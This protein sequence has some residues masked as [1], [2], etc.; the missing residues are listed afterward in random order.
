MTRSRAAR[1]ASPLVQIQPPQPERRGVSDAG[2]ANLSF[3]RLT[4]DRSGRLAS[5]RGRAAGHSG[6]LEWLCCRVGGVRHD[7]FTAEPAGY[8]AVRDRC[9]CERRKPKAAGK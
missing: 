3:T 1:E 8:G 7:R 4:Q 2:A 5:A 9:R 6:V